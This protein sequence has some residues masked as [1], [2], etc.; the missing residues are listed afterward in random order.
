MRE[1]VEIY[2]D[3]KNSLNEALYYVVPTPVVYDE[4]EIFNGSSYPF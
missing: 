1:L 2:L 3:I 4:V